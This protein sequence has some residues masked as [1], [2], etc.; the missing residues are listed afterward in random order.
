[1]I[2]M[3]AGFA[4]GLSVVAVSAIGCIFECVQ[5]F[6]NFMVAKREDLFPFLCI[7]YFLA[8]GSIVAWLGHGWFENVFRRPWAVLVTLL[9]AL[10]FLVSFGLMQA[11]V[12]R[13]RRR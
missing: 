2:P 8:V 5:L 11:T 9:A 10:H 12:W 6:Y 3:Q 1:M 4:I 13:K 7:S